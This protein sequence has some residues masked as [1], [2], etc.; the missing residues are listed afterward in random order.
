MIAVD[1]NVIVR[2]VTHD[3][4]DQARRA[5]WGALFARRRAMLLDTWV[6]VHGTEA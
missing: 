4:P 2:I 6:T 3:D 5:K 1:T